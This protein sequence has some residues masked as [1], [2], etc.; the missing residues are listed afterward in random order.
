VSVLVSGVLGRDRHGHEVSGWGCADGYPGP[1]PVRDSKT[2]TARP[3]I[4]GAASQS[5]FVDGVK[6]TF[7]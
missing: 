7:G 4:L 1:V 2:S 3:W 6:D 5:V